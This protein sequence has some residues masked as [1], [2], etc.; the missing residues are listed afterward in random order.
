MP[1]NPGGP[2]G[3]QRARS[4][5]PS[6]TATGES[7]AAASTTRPIARGAAL[8]LRVARQSRRQRF[9]LAPASAHLAALRYQAGA[10]GRQRIDRLQLSSDA[11]L[12][13]F[14]AWT[15]LHLPLEALI[16]PAPVRAAR[17][18]PASAASRSRSERER[19][20]EWR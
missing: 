13:L 14:R 9:E 20:P 15:W 4:N 2:D 17:L 3:Q 12:G 7:A 6:P 18:P 11:P 19:A 1:R 8:R 5:R 16:Y 10:R